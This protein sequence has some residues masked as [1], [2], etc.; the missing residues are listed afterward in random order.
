M[1][2]SKFTKKVAKAIPQMALKLGQR[3]VDQACTWW[4]NQPKVPE[5]MKNI[6]K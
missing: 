2:D 5:S 3:T 1:K 4:Y 6:K